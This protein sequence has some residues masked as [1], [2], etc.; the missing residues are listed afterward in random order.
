MAIYNISFAGAG[1]VAGILCKELYDKGFRI[2]R[3]VSRSE[4]QGKA[5]AATCGADWSSELSFGDNCDLIIVAVSDH[6][7]PGVLKSLSCNKKT[8]VV[9]TAGSYGLGI[10]PAKIR[11]KGVFYPLQTFSKE[12]K[13]SF[14]GLP[15]F[16]EADNDETLARLE[17]LAAMLGAKCFRADTEQRKMLHV[18]AVFVNNFTNFMLTGGNYLAKEAGISPEI[19]EPLIRETF[20]KALEMG[21]EASQT[22]PAVRNDLNTIKKHLELLSFS[23][24]LQVLYKEISGSIIKYYGKKNGKLQ[25]G[26]G[27][28]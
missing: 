20:L 9:H 7:L 28:R 26:A 11:I 18:A 25:R 22:G 2:T 15:V 13:V 23:P 17:E 10:F 4:H 6:A 8:L 27:K 3:I 21:P 19:L 12:R 14:D 24:D 5:L 1:R 16:I